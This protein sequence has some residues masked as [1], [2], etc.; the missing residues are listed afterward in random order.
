LSD[1]L[2]SNPILSEPPERVTIKEAIE[3][4]RLDVARWKAEMAF[5]ECGGNSEFGRQ[6]RAWIAEAERIIGK[7]ENPHA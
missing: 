5:L 7:S 1:P 4:L 6:L 3:A 2:L